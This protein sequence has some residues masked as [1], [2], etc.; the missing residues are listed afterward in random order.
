MYEN[1]ENVPDFFAA[2]A[3]AEPDF[4]ADELC[5]LKTIFLELEKV[6][7]DI[8]VDA[9]DSC[10]FPSSYIINLLGKAL[11]TYQ[12]STLLMDVLQR[13]IEFL[14]VTN[15]SV[16]QVIGAALEKIIELLNNVFKQ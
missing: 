10:T 9:S 12:K 4:K 1:G 5:I 3:S 13:V 6:I 11:I 2:G 8:Q 14:S 7:D 16:F 15:T